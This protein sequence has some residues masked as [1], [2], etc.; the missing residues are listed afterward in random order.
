MAGRNMDSLVQLQSAVSIF[1]VNPRSYNLVTYAI[2]VPLVALLAF[3]TLRKQLSWIV[4]W[5]ALAVA[6]PLSMLPMYH[7]QHD[8]KLILLTIPASA[9][10]WAKRDGTGWVSLFVTGAGILIGGDIFSAARIL[11]TRNIL[12]P[13]PTLASR[14]TTVILTRPAPLILLVMVVFYLV[15]LRRQVLFCA[16]LEENRQSHAT[17]PDSNATPLRG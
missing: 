12:V 1:F 5:F 11:L 16:R 4:I 6:A 9:I 7:F 2:C 14:L 13:G 17:E 15:A 3:F 8:A 10:L